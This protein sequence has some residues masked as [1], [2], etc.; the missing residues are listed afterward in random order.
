MPS[1]SK[2]ARADFML[3]GRQCAESIGIS[4]N[5]F[6]KWRVP[7]TKD[8]RENLYSLKDV[9]DVY[10]QR[11][12]RESRPAIAEEVRAELA[13]LDPAEMNPATLQV[14]LTYE[15]KRLT[16]AQAEA[17]EEKNRMMRHEIAP[18]G[19]VTFVLAS[20]GNSLASSLDSVPTMLVRQAGIAPK[21]ADKA[22]AAT[23]SVANQIAELGDPDWVARRY[24]DYLAE[25]AS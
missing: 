20:I 15:R 4:V 21:D 8:G 24:D 5:S 14:E 12:E 3:N 2:E 23:A 18:F 19:F 9:L 25:S 7:C 1:D 13:G 6:H 11:V 16:A 22:R 10:R 17:Q